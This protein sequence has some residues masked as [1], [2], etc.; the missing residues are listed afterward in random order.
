[1]NKGNTMGLRLA[2]VALAT[3]P[4]AT[5][6]AQNWPSRPVTLVAP[7]SPGSTPDTVTRLLAQ[8]LTEQV[9]QQVVAVSRVGASGN[10][11]SESVAKAAPDGYT[12]LLGS[13]ANT[14]N[15]HFM[16]SIGFTIDELAPVSSVAAAP[17]ILAVHPSV[18]A[19]N[20]RE[21]LDLLKAKPGTSSAIPGFGST[22]HLSSVLLQSTGGVQLTIV[23]YQGGGAA[24]QGLLG[25]QVPMAFLTSVIVVPRVKGGQLRAIG[26]TSAKRISS[27]PELPTLAEQGLTGFEVSAWFGVFAPAK[28]PKPL[29][30][31]LSEETRKAV[32][33][34]DTRKRLMDLGAEPLGSTP[35]EF[36]AFVKSEYAKWGVVVKEA[37]I[38]AE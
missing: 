10:I 25:N 14:L 4:F 32:A 35:E 5:A 31:R 11:G 34:A 16:K 2:I 8:K 37:G 18:P 26:V 6:Y 27:L 30:D 9:G 12:L 24:L 3:L 17:D 29:I 20:L 22:P 23:P 33:S 7:S 28:T 21:L 19:Q 36:T 1:M 13:I 38:K 15:P